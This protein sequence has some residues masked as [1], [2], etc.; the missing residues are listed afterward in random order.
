VIA[1]E[2]HIA[3]ISIATLVNQ[4]SHGGVVIHRFIST[5]ELATLYHSSKQIIP[6]LVAKHRNPLWIAPLVYSRT[7]PQAQLDRF[8]LPLLIGSFCPIVGVNE[9]VAVRKCLL[10]QASSTVIMVNH[11]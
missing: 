9:V 3:Y 7:I 10:P 4:P 1:V 11:I 6:I 2:T 5:G 8:Q